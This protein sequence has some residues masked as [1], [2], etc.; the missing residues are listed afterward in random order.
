MILGP[1]LV[2][3][4][5]ALQSS[6]KVFYGTFLATV[7]TPLFMV[8]G[9]TLTSAVFLAAIRFR[10][11]GEGRGTLLLLNLWTAVSFICFFLARKYLPPVIFASVDIGT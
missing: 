2:F 8:I 1:L 10:L 5:L 3:L 6:G 11:P 7:S 9:V 4:G